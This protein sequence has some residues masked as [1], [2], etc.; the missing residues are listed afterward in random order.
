MV[1]RFEKLSYYI[2]SIY[3]NIQKIEKEVME[4][5]GLRGSYAQY[6]VAISHHAEGITVT[7]LCDICD[8]DK[9]AASR[10]V[11]EMEER[12]LVARKSESNSMY[13][14]KLMLTDKGNEIAEYVLKN[15]NAA[16]EMA[17][18]GLDDSDRKIFYA[19]LE[20]IEAN[21]KKICKEGIHG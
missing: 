2:Y 13:R 1:N 9:S 10:I 16:V 19:T 7:Q 11:A 12:G 18:E 20:L 15:V 4:R 6:I 17:G 3:R 21:I 5:Y 14:A 8:K